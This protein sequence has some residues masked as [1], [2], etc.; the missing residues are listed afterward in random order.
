MQINVP[1]LSMP[2]DK[3]RIPQAG[4]T[5]YLR[6]DTKCVAMYLDRVYIKDKTE[7][8]QCSWTEYEMFNDELLQHSR[9]KVFLL[10]E[11]T[12]YPPVM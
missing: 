3:A 1:S 6:G 8:A 11:L 2:Q 9:E 4:E 7:Y 10:S 12:V 5:V